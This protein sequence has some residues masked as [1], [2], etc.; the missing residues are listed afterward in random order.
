MM[1]ALFIGFGNV[2][3][4]IARI[5]TVERSRFPGMYPLDD[6]VPVGIVTRRG[7]SLVDPEGI[8]LRLALEEIESKGRFPK[9]HPGYSEISGEEAARTLD[10]DVIVELSTLSV[11]NRGEPAATHI[12][13]ALS[14]KRHAV[15]ANK[16]P[17]A[18]SYREL[19]GLAESAGKKFLF[20]TTV[21]DGAP[22]FNLREFCLKGCVVTAFDGILNSTTNYILSRMEEGADFADAVREAQETGVAE[23]DPRNDIDGWDAAAKVAALANVLLGAEMTPLDVDRQGIAGVTAGDIRKAALSGNRLK[24][25]CRAWKD[26]GKAFGKVG[27]EEVP[28]THH[29]SLVSG[30]GAVLRI[31]TDL[32]GPI[33]VT[34]EK[35]DL[36]DTAY[37]VLGDL[38][39]I[40]QLY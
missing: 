11:E 22:V 1:K 37:G 12:R 39:S 31:H 4:T 33:L 14:R 35:P 40:R 26:R 17:V 21:M 6:L 16:G 29:F 28:A 30:E 32:M 9:A 18:F 7:G 34:Q 15:S 24:L 10:Y 2:G 19:S 25:V 38:I 23:A 36:Y 20:E 5:L 8:D 3:R 27:I 13:T